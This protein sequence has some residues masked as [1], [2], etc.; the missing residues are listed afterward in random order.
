VLLDERERAGNRAAL[1]VRTSMTERGAHPGKGGGIRRL[2]VSMP[3]SQDSAHG[4]DSILAWLVGDR[5]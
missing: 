3:D 4:S 5:R 1:S 2:A